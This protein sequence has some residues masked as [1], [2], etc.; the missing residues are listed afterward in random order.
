V[1]KGGAY[2]FK[3]RIVRSVWIEEDRAHE[4]EIQNVFRPISPDGSQVDHDDGQR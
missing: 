1:T 4:Q 2:F 3:E